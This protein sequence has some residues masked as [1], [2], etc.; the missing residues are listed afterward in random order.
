MSDSDQ[1][2]NGAAPPGAPARM[3]VVG[4]DASTASR[5]ALDLALRFSQITGAR[6]VAANVYGAIPVSFAPYGSAPLYG[7]LER[8]L[9]QDAERLLERLD[10]LGVERRAV[11]ATSVAQGLH[12]LAAAEGAALI[13]IGHARRHGAE[14]LI[15]G[16]LAERVLQGSPCAVAVMPD[17]VDAR[18]AIDVIA[19]AFDGRDEARNALDAACALAE[20]LGARIM[21][22]GAVQPAPISEALSE[23]QRQAVQEAM[24]EDLGR[25]LDD[26]AAKLPAGLRARPVLAEGLAA[27]VLVDACSRRVDLLIMGSRGYGPVRSLLL[28]SV[29]CDVIGH[30]ACPV[31]VVPRATPAGLGP[32]SR[33]QFHT[34]HHDQ[35][36]SMPSETTHTARAGDALRV[37]SLSGGLSQHGE[38]IEVL[39][40]VG[41]E[42]YRVRWE[43]GHESIHY[44]ADGTHITGHTAHDRS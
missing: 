23:D 12:E 10:G 16:S 37:D 26:V 8:I 13:A 29:A 33:K 18:R 2:A 35:G 36:A 28:G 42:H 34:S 39:G 7:R 22:V 1:H 30:A 9:R 14:A 20:R 27:D 19:V 3:F 40:S 25:V 41:H 15:A 32:I 21:L 4:Y 43:D 11:C 6:V 31:I 38:I 5:A 17:D 24:R 44:P